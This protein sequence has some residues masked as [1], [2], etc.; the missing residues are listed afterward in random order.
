[1][2]KTMM[3]AL[4]VLVLA[5]CREEDGLVGYWVSPHTSASYTF[6]GDGT[7]VYSNGR[8]IGHDCTWARKTEL[9]AMIKRGGAIHLESEVIGGS[10]GGDDI[11]VSTG[12]AGIDS[13]DRCTDESPSWKC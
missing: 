4:V 9:K 6:N 11:M 13:F 1:M 3:V 2:I 5:G 12:G 7:C 10:R 8:G